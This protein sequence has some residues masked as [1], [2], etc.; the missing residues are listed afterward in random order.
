MWVYDIETLP[1]AFVLCAYNGEIKKEFVLWKLYEE[2]VDDYESL[3]AFIS[4]CKE[5]CGFNNLSF[6][7]P[8]ISKIPLMNRLTHKARIHTIYKTAQDFINDPKKFREKPSIKQIDLFKLHHF[9]NKGKMVSLKALQVWMNWENVQEMPI[10]HTTI[11][12]REQ[13]STIVE[14]CWNDVMSTYEFFLKSKAKIEEREKMGYPNVPD[15]NVGEQII[16]KAIKKRS[17]KDIKTIKESRFFKKEIIVDDCILPVIQFETKGFSAL[18]EYFKRQ[19]IPIRQGKLTTD[20][21]FRNILHK[22]FGSNL[23]YFGKETEKGTIK[24]VSVIHKG[25]RYDFGVGGIH[26]SAPAGRYF[27]DDD[28]IIK[29]Y[30][31]ISFYPRLAVEYQFSPDHLR[32]LGFVELYT[33]IFHSRIDYKKKGNKIKAEELKLAL[34]GAY[35]KSNSVYS[36]LY[37]P[38]FTMDITINGQLMIAMLAEKLSNLAQVVQV[39]TDGITVRFKRDLE[40][41]IDELLQEWQDDTKMELESAEYAQMVIRDV[42][43]YMAIKPDGSLKLKGDFEVEREPHK[44]PSFRIIPIALINYFSAGTPVDVTFEQNKDPFLYFGRYKGNAAW[45]ALSIG[46][47]EENKQSVE[48]RTHLGKMVRYIPVNKGVMLYKEDRKGKLI[49]VHA[50]TEVLIWN[51]KVDFDFQSINFEFFKKRCRDTIN[52]IDQLQSRLC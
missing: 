41:Q 35:G 42:N 51:K 50:D 32:D 9:D 27:S 40:G 23:Q 13:L 15:A 14:Y 18:L 1:N 48:E 43:T 26:G 22:R 38:K 37:D 7:Y 45:Q 28:Y 6:D 34:N 3:K 29:D 36:A 8:V 12:N 21:I 52:Q 30:D 33:E 31:V 4:E 44:D 2:Q 17:G 49:A 5:M 24:R 47:K 10:H 11:V 19:V 25:L 46:L 20:G 16:L 39:N